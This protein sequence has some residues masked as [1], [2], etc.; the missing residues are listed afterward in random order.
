MKA[1]RRRNTV[2]DGLCTINTDVSELEFY[3]DTLITSV[4]FGA[5]NNCTILG[6]F[7]F[8][9]CVNLT[10]IDFTNANYLTQINVAAFC[11]CSLLSKIKFP[12][13]INLIGFS[14]FISCSGLS[15]IDLS[16]ITSLTTLRES[17]FIDCNNVNVLRLRDNFSIPNYTFNFNS[18]KNVQVYF[19]GPLPV[20]TVINRG[21]Y[22]LITVP[23][24]PIN[25]VA[26]GVRTFHYWNY[27][28]YNL[29]DH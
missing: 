3:Y 29:L 26:G 13:S 4:L 27:R 19:N 28:N 25:T 7:A 12:A 6:D 20:G 9:N 10:N 21:N 24:G 1:K 22:T 16:D 2:V 5:N 15:E 8:A 11:N 14:V 18:S 17:A 23:A